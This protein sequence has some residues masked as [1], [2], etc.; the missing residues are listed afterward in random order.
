MS[1][2]TLPPIPVESVIF[3]R[4]GT[5]P[6]WISGEIIE[7]QRA[8]V[9]K[10]VIGALPE[11]HTM[12]ES[13]AVPVG[14]DLSWLGCALSEI[15]DHFP[16]LTH[17]YLWSV[18][19][20]DSL[21]GLPAG[22]QC[23]DVRFCPNIGRLP[24]L[25]SLA[26]ETL[27]LASLPLIEDLPAQGTY[28]KLFEFIATDCT[29][30]EDESI[31]DWI[32]ACPSLTHIDLS[33]SSKL[34]GISKW[35]SNLE[36]VDLRCNRCANLSALPRSSDGKKSWP[37]KLRRL[38]LE[39]TA[40]STLGDFP[41]SLDYVNL[42]RMR[43]LK[44]LPDEW[45]QFRKYPRTL[46]LHGCGIL[47]P[48][49]SE[50][51]S[52]P[53]ENVAERTRAYFRDVEEFGPGS[54]KRC[55]VMVLGNGSAGKS[56]LSLNLT[57][58]DPQRTRKDYEP[59]RDRVISTHGVEFLPWKTEVNIDGGAE[60]VDIHVWDFG[61]Q[62]IYH[63]T[64]RLFLSTGTIFILLWNPEQDGK[65]P[66]D[67]HDTWR[68]LSYW[69]DYIEKACLPYAPQ[70]AVVCSNRSNSTPDLEKQL[71]TN[72][73]ESHFKTYKHFY[74][75]SLN[76]SGRQL[77]ALKT[78]L[79]SK[80]GELISEQGTCV[81]SYW[82]IAQETV[83]A[84]VEQ[85]DTD[86]ALA[87][88]YQQMTPEDF[89]AVIDGIVKDTALKQRERF[90]LLTAAVEEAKFEM[91]PDR[92]RR[93]LGF[94]SHSGWI[95]WKEGLYEN[96]AIIGQKWALDGIYTLLER[97]DGKPD[98]QVFFQLQKDQGRFTQADLNRWGWEEQF[99]PA[100]Q[101][102]LLTFLR[103]IG[104]C[105]ELNHRERDW[106]HSHSGH[107]ISISHLPDCPLQKWNRELRAKGLEKAPSLSD[108]SIPLEP[109]HSGHWYQILSAFG[110]KFG[111]S[112][113][114]AKDGFRI[115]NE[116]GQA[117]IVTAEF[118]PDYLRGEIVIDARGKDA[119][120][121]QKELSET[122]RSV[123][124]D[125]VTGK[126][127]GRPAIGESGGTPE[128]PIKVF[129][130]YTWDP[131]DWKGDPN[132]EEPTNAICEALKGEKAVSLYRDKNEIS[133]TARDSVT[134][135]MEQ[136][137]DSSWV[138]M[139]TS[140]K[141]WRSE[142]C[143][144]EMW[145]LL[146]SYK[147]RDANFSTNLIIIEHES[148]KLRTSTKALDEVIAEWREKDDMPVRMRALHPKPENI[149]KLKSHVIPILDEDLPHIHARDGMYKRWGRE[150][151]EVII[152]WIKEKIGL[153]PPLP[154]LDE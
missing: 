101:E 92:I 144:W 145:A 63:N 17:L 123:M 152:D 28:P 143:M 48:P 6:E 140:E 26:L 32:K 106:R 83:E 39:G 41:D 65:E 151:P 113:T 84:W 153:N 78:W 25:P 36:L 72:M 107:Y 33:G 11:K 67:P 35:P 148:C 61:G 111:T 34:R 118:D 68:P 94:L 27:V 124:G 125:L 86:A 132:Y 115:L 38:E 69:L 1:T 47:M 70:I 30:L 141:Y 45:G 29:E 76:H 98:S 108:E 114:Y 53:T 13:P 64:H 59:A 89:G 109:F 137:T 133:P 112:G 85:F 117:A 51:G 22:L 20:L 142:Y 87:R 122:I 75:D 150:T 147:D 23:L 97:V 82:E 19:G 10:I 5:P 116:E 93:T 96:R 131:W 146:Q 54:V 56:C 49:A 127:R 126:T 3:S 130:S 120:T 129:V 8:A 105:F 50:H 31:N 40:L 15:G 90:P 52:N 14:T 81:P 138:I 134:K 136:I 88:R 46:F 24:V 74:I 55:K 102:L 9:T 12:P 37:E 154:N 77:N 4:D 139:V 43:N 71:R 79:K 135:F 149:E 73:G 16:N 80:S 7:K 128:G 60:E 121:F 42:G 66:A 57:G 110:E 99:S 100:E 18:G 21:S 2:A 62:E 104:L 119:A 58:G 91:T 44:S 95:F 103:E